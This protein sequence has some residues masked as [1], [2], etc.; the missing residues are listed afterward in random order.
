[1]N[2][3]E[4]KEYDQIRG[5]LKLFYGRYP[6]IVEMGDFSPKWLSDISRGR[7]VRDPGYFKMKRLLAILDELEAEEDC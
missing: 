7:Y 5:R 4:K 1:M 6:K 2:E 3:S